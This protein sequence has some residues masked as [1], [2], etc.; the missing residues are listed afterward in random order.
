MQKNMKMEQLEYFS[1]P[2]YI[3]N[4]WKEHYSDFLL[5][6]QE[7]AVREFNLLQPAQYPL[8]QNSTLHQKKLK[9]LLVVSPSSSGKTLVGEMAALQE[10]SLQKKVLYL[11]PL[12]IL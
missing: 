7:K 1:V 8:Y 11:V 12:R 9:N 4:I 5:P 2:H 10:I 6:V 3:I